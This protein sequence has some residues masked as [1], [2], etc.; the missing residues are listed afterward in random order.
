MRKTINRADVT[1]AYNMLQSGDVE[2]AR[3]HLRKLLNG[4]RCSKCLEWKEHYHFYS[5][6][7]NYSRGECRECT[8]AKM[9]DVYKVK[10]G[11]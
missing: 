6:G 11:V 2:G 9:K 8:L 5:D 3:S 10:K 7:N 1:A 4:K